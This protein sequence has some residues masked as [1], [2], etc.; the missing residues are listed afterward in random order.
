MD[1][2]EVARRIR[3]TASLEEIIL[4]ALT[5]YGQ[6]DDRRRAR[7]AGFNYHLTKPTTLTALKDVLGRSSNFLPADINAIQSIV[8]PRG[9]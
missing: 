7:E 3:D 5:G 4:V 9:Q 8:K 1:G 6:E 2:Y